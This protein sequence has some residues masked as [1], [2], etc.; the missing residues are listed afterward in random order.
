MED[1]DSA[2]S[3]ASSSRPASVAMS[4]HGFD[5]ES[6]E[7]LAA[8]LGAAM[9]ELGKIIDISTLDGVTVAFDYDEALAT[10]DRGYS[11]THVLRRTSDVALG[12]AMTPAVLREGLLKSHI[13]LAANVASTL[14]SED[15]YLRGLTIHTLSHECAHVE[16]TAAWDKCFPDE[17]LRPSKHSSL[18]E[19]WRYDVV[20]ACWDEYAA[21]R[22]AGT[23]GHDPLT[24]YE[25][26]FLTVLEQ[27]DEK[28]AALV[29]EFHGGS[30]DPL[31]GPIFGVYGNLM[32]FACYM[33]GTMAA[34]GKQGDY[35]DFVSAALQA[36]WFLPYCTR[37]DEACNA[38]FEE[39]GRWPDKRLFDTVADIL[40]EA[41]VQNVMDIWR[42]DDDRYRIRIH[43]PD[44][45]LGY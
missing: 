18:L 31:V 24:G 10:L 25:T 36:S 26:T 30:A 3:L 29:R 34:V 16:V 39:F 9:F 12:V 2:L 13:V 22:I 45:N 41:V 1:I 27:C 28:V 20:T 40:E 33:L 11:T 43:H 14:I 4:F 19:F 32:K 38:I 17:L 5:Q 42:L 21:C 35:S 6:A 8:G 44:A 37:L 7:N 23:L 15:E